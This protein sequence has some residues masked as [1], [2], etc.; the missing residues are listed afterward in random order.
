M[1]QIVCKRE[2][3]NTLTGN[4]KHAVIGKLEEGGAVII[5]ILLFCV[6]FKI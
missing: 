3:V 4:N 2:K 1:L 6:L 5:G